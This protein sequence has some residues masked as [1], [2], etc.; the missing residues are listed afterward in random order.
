MSRGYL[1]FSPSPF[2]CGKS[3]LQNL[4]SAVIYD[5]FPFWIS[6]KYLSLDIKQQHSVKHYWLLK[7]FLL[8]PWLVKF[9]SWTNWFYWFSLNIEN[10]Y[11]LKMYWWPS[12]VICSMVRLL[13]L[14]HIHHFLSQFYLLCNLKA[15]FCEIWILSNKYVSIYN[16]WYWPI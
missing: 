16:S 12:A 6:M 7:L 9:V 3:S 8:T 1:K 2:H 11:S 5:L 13:S 15:V 10:L 14:W 4:L